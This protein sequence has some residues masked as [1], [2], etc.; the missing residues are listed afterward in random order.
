MLMVKDNALG[1]FHRAATTSR[2]LKWT[3]NGSVPLGPTM[4]HH[5][6]PS[7]TLGDNRFLPDDGTLGRGLKDAI[8]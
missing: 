6:F 7:F 3:D 1:W 2:P 5:F 4:D 8:S